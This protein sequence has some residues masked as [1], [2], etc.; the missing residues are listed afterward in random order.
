VS[1]A[2]VLAVYAA[3]LYVLT[4]SLQAAQPLLLSKQ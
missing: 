1:L 3:A 4:C 2:D